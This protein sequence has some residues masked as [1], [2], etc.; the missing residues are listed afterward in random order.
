MTSS[1]S[2]KAINK[3]L[4]LAKL[5]KILKYSKINKNRECIARRPVVY[6]ILKGARHAEMKGHTKLHEEIQSNG[7]DNCIDVIKDGISI[8][9][10]TFL[11]FYTF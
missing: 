6:E 1:K 3:V 11:F 9:F 10:V 2:W 8:S 5:L 4:Y 7:E